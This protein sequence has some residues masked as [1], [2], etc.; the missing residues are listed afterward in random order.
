MTT[1]ATG[2]VRG[3]RIA[4]RLPFVVALAGIV[5]LGVMVMVLAPQLGPY[6]PA[7]ISPAESLQGPNPT[8]LLG[9]DQLGRDVFSR[10]IAGARTAFLAPLALAA[11]SVTLSVVLA[12]LAGFV[13]G[14]VDDLISRII[15]VLYSIPSL[16]VAIV[17]VGVTGGGFV[18]ALVILLIFGIPTN[19]RV[20]RAAVLERVRL[21]YM[22]AARTVGLSKIRIVFTQLIPALTPLIV[23]SLFIQFTYGV[24]EVSSLSFLGLG[25]PVGSPDWGRMLFENRSALSSNVWATAAPG[26]CIVALAVSANI[27]G[28]WTFNRF[29]KASRQR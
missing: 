17:V 23:T 3:L 8:H 6:D 15:D 20:L 11:G 24:V 25:V 7:L 21:P 12:I 29:E 1:L 9:T 16:I 27:V 2:A 28:D 22:E 14:R 26:I 5:L 13:G 4:T 10:V 18:M 19:V